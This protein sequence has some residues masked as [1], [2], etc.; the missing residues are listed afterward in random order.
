MGM[1][2][3]CCN[4]RHCPQSMLVEVKV[5]RADDAQLASQLKGGAAKTLLLSRCR[6]VGPTANEA[7]L[8]L[9]LAIYANGI[10]PAPWK[11]RA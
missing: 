8:D 3:Y 1:L 2:N 11:G 7:Y 10:R 5:H 6:I 4:L 9:E